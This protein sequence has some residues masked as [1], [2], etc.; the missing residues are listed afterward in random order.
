MAHYGEIMA[1]EEHDKPELIP[2][3]RKQPDYLR[4]HAHIEC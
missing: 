4:L 2:H 1:D 3:F